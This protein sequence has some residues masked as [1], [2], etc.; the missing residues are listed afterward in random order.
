MGEVAIVLIKL[1]CKPAKT[2]LKGNGIGLNL[3]AV[4]ACRASSESGI[5]AFNLRSSATSLTGLFDKI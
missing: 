4:A 1:V 5:Q 3:K 2:S